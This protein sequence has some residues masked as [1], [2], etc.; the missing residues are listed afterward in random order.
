MKVL[1]VGDVHWSQYSSIVRDRSEQ[2]TY[3][4]DN[5][6]DSVNWV[7]QLAEEENVRHVICL[8]DFFDSY[9]LHAEEIKALNKI[10]WFNQKWRFLVGNHE[11]YSTNRSRSSVSIFEN[12]HTIYSEPELITWNNVELCFLP[13]MFDSDRKTLKDYFGEKA[14]KRIIFS[15]NDIKGINY[16]VTVSRTGYEIE[17]IEQ[18]CDLFIN[19]HI[20]NGEKITDKIINLGNL[21]GQNFSEDAFRYEHHIMILDTDT[22]DYKF[23]R[24]PYAMNFYKVD[25]CDKDIDYI[26]NIS[27]KLRSPAVLSASCDEDDFDYINK[28]FNPDMEEDKLIPRNCNVVKCR[29]TVNRKIKT[30]LTMEKQKLNVEN[31]IDKFSEYMKEKITNSSVLEEELGEVLK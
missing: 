2:F 20:H 15:H 13:Y 11:V 9:S 18:N 26:N 5:L 24:N 16:G 17:D 21:T 19:G 10:K 27:M 7:N 29:I 23:V 6:I 12:Y 31:Y 3:R 1:V 8:G 28:R 22:L 4:L 14:K 30:E 25:F